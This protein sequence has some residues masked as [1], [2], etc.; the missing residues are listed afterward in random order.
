MEHNRIV[1]EKPYDAE[2]EYLESTGTQWIDTEYKPNTDTRTVGRCYFN[3]FIGSKANYVFGVFTRP[4]NYGFNVGLSR[5]FFNVPWGSNDGIKLIGLIPQT[6]EDYEFDISKTGYKVNGTSY[7]TPSTNL[8]NSTRNMYLFWSNGTTAIG[9]NGRIY[10]C[11]IYDGNTL[12]RDFIPVR[13]GNV[14]YLY[15]KVS[16]KLFGN[17]GTGNFILGQDVANPVPNIRRVFRFGNKRFVMPSGLEEGVDYQRYD[18]LLGDN[19]A[20]IK[21]Y[22]NLWNNQLHTVIG[23]ATKNFIT[24]SSRINAL[25]VRYNGSG[26]L[27][28]IF[29]TGAEQWHIAD[30]TPFSSMPDVVD[31]RFYIQNNIGYCEENG[32]KFTGRDMATTWNDNSE[33]L[34]YGGK[35]QSLAEYDSTNNKLISSLVPCQLFRSIPASFD[36]NGISRQAGECGMIDSISGKFYGNVAN[37]G[38]F[39]VRN[40]N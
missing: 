31:F 24:S 10:Y 28:V 23:K 22:A 19:I 26:Y 11:K 13:R 27:L 29:R 20:T 30:I 34:I 3:S 33:F 32:S 5:Q 37:A 15:D 18:W 39:T 8:V 2:V 25:N 35:M 21:W 12:V 38:T 7:E 9:M 17:Q 16:G 40:D 6:N 4:N 36:A 1:Y 14:G